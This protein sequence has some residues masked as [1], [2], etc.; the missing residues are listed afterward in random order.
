MQ[1]LHEEELHGHQ[2]GDPSKAA[3]VIIEVAN[4]Q[5]P[6]LHLFLGSDAYQYAE[7]KMDSLKETMEAHQALA[8]STDFEQEALH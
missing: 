2:P 8:T 4:R 6:P 1:R 7:Q 5:T 3:D